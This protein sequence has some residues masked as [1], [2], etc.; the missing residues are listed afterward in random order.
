ML[1]WLRR[2]FFLLVTISLLIILTVFVLLRQSLPVLEGEVKAPF[3]NASVTIERDAQGIPLISGSDRTDVAFATGYLHAQERFFQMDLNRRNSAGE[4]SELVGELALDH[5][6][7]QRK[8]R[9]RKVAQ[10]AVEMMTAEHLALLKAYTDGVNHGLKDLGQKPFEY[11]LLGVEPEPWKNEDSFL[12]IFS[13][14]MDLNDDE[15]KLDNLK[16]FI[17]R[18]TVPAVIDFLSPLKTRWDSPM[19]PGELSDVPTPGAELVDLRSKE[20]ELYANLGGTTLED[21]LIGS[22]NWAVSG[23]LTDHGGAI[24]QDDMHLSHRVP[25]IW[26]RAS[27]SYPHPDQPQDRVSITG[28][29]LPGTPFIVVGSNTHIAW[30]FTN[31]GGD[32]VDLVELDIDEGQ[33]MTNDGPKPLE[34]WTETINIKDQ[35]PVVVEYSGTHWGPVVDSAYDNTQYALRW[36]AHLPE[37]T[38]ASLVNLEVTRNVEQGMAI[39]NRS[40]IPRRTLRW[41]TVKAILAG[42]LPDRFQTVQV[43]I[44]LTHCPGSRLMITGMAGFLRCIIPAYITLWI[45]EYGLPMPVS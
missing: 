14:Y 28:V 22:N 29:T 37:A 34:H 40:G 1:T 43:S 33:Y 42:P 24:I 20:A 38:N 12:V 17:S 7:R 18:V 36:T 26:Y 2:S 31:T 23:E 35:E 5:D 13:M 16:G 25:T 41:V 27:L 39:A 30:G 19:Q 6:K 3:L 4:L 9:F 44:P 21:S 45:R 11:L 15:V 8:H 10:Q 32:W